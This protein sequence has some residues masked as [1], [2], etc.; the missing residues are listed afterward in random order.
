MLKT[1]EYYK[2][3]TFEEVELQAFNDDIDAQAQLGYMYANGSK[4]E[5]N[6]EKG[7][8]W[9]KKAAESGNVRAM[10]NYAEYL[11]KGYGTEVNH[12]LAM[13][14]ARFAADNGN[15]LGMFVV[16]IYYM[17]GIHFE[18]DLEK[19]RVYLYSAA[20][21]GHSLAQCEIA[22]LIINGY[23]D[24]YDWNI[25]LNM[26]NAAAE[27]GYEKAKKQ[28]FIYSNPKNI[29]QHAINGNLHA[30]AQLG[31]MYSNGQDGLACDSAQAFY[32]TSKAAEQGNPRAMANLGMDYMYGDGVE[33][34]PDEAIRWFKK[35]VAK[36]NNLGRVALGKCYCDGSYL[37]R[38]IHEAIKLFSLAAAEG[39]KR[40][41]YELGVMYLEGNGVEKDIDY[42]IELLIKS[43]E[44]GYGPAI[45]LLK[46]LSADKINIALISCNLIAERIGISRGAVHCSIHYAEN[47]N[48]YQA[49]M[50]HGF[51]AEKANHL[52]DQF[53]GKD[54]SHIGGDNAKNGPDRLVDG[55]RIQ[56]KYCSL[57]SKC[58]SECFDESGSFRYFNPDGTPMQIEVPSNKYGAAIKAMESRISSGQVKGVS[59]PKQAREIIRRGN[60]T[61]EQARLIAKAGT[62]PSLTYD[63]INCAVLAGYAGGLS[64]AISFS[65][66]VWNGDDFDKALESACCSGFKVGGIAWVGSVITAQ[67]GR[68][69][70]EQSLR[71][72]T[73]WVVKQMG[74]KAASWLSSGLSTGGRTLS[75]A[76]AMNHASKLLRGNVVTIAVTT[77][78]LSTADL[79]RIFSGRIS[80][81]QLFKNVSTTAA[82]VAGGIGGW[83]AGA[84]AGASAGAVLGSAVPIIGTGIGAGIGTV[85][86]GLAGSFLGGS[87]G[88]GVSKAILNEFVEDD[89]VEMLGIIER[90]YVSMAQLLLISQSE[91][92]TIAE[93]L[94]GLDLRNEVMNMY[95]SDNREVYACSMLEPIFYKVIGDRKNVDLPTCEQLIVGF[96]KIFEKSYSDDQGSPYNKGQALNSNENIIHENNSQKCDV[97]SGLG[98]TYCS[99]CGGSGLVDCLACGKTGVVKGIF[100]EKLCD[101][102]GGVPFVECKKCKG[103]GEFK[104]KTCAGT[105]IFKVI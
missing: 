42:A 88:Q 69:G 26:L 22:M 76:P 104:C 105:G 32:W 93:Q 46:K 12:D 33:K 16:G 89:A 14:Y 103:A 71:G 35:A 62:V 82:G 40:S 63:A 34:D 13:K 99:G 80:R 60:F 19:A 39:H 94:Q 74:P 85:V 10:A 41:Q 18:K 27:Q 11:R 31:F 8:L 47:I 21:M 55:I 20:I 5:K 4:V 15:R 61:Y 81:A 48:I 58:I 59:D 78:I 24:A 25:A 90:S 77:A 7:V 38:N 95:S 30:Q 100:K 28:Y 3:Y 97:C 43:S 45:D 54:A 64:A 65:I 2:N 52:Y 37:D 53:S 98:V 66:A 44:Q 87:V 29:E 73:D 75:G 6:P 102:C 101:K 50:G 72:T 92:E 56:T 84:S 79:C 86:G 36:G 83:Q 9:T 51:A 91:A 67:I 23:T 68:T 57:G 96:G 17:D 70:V 49:K 1:A